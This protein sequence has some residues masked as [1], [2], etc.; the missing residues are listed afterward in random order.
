VK[1]GN[2]LLVEGFLSFSPRA[3]PPA[4]RKEKI[5]MEF[6]VSVPGLWCPLPEFLVSATGRKTGED[7]NTATLSLISRYLKL[8]F[9][10]KSYQ[11]CVKKRLIGTR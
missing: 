8:F 6:L 9:V 1:H 5:R 11:A 3:C 4:W 10:K 2:P 7:S